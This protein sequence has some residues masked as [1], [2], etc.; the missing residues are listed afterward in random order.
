MSYFEAFVILSIYAFLLTFVSSGF[1][2]EIK[3]TTKNDVHILVKSFYL[4]VVF[5]IIL[6][7]TITYIL[8]I[9][10]LLKSTGVLNEI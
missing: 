10:Y 1:I 3:I 4:I 8:A 6:T 9:F 2:R 5:I 7:T